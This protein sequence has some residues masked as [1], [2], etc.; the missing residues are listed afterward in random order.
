MAWVK[1]TAHD[2]KLGRDVAIKVV[3]EAFA[4][5]PDRLARFQREAQAIAALNHPNIVTIYSIEE[6]DNHSIM[7]MELVEGHSLAEVIPKGGLPLERLLQIAI[8][9]ADALAAAHQKGITHRDLKPANIMLGD[10]EHQ[11]RVK[12][13]DFGLA[14]LAGAAA[15]PAGLSLLPTAPV[16]GEGRI[17][18]TVAYMSPEQAEGK[19]IDSRSDLF[20]LGIILYEMATGQRPFTGE[21][22]LSIMASIVRDTPT[23]VTT[24]N[25]ALPRDLG[26]IIRRALSK[27]LERRYQTAKDLRNDLEELKGSLES[28]E[29]LAEP[30]GPQAVVYRRHVRVWQWAALGLAVVAIVAIAALVGLLRHRPDVGTGQT[31]ASPTQM[32]PLTSTGNSNLPAISPDGKYVAYVQDDNKQQSVWV[33]HIASHSVVRIVPFSLGVSIFGLSVTPDDSFV[34]V[35]SRAPDDPAPALWRV[36]LLGGAPRKV[37]D[38]IASPPGWSPDGTQMAF[39][40]RETAAPTRDTLMV[41]DADGSHPRALATRTRPRKVPVSFERK[42]AQH[43]SGLVVRRPERCRRGFR[44]DGERLAGRQCQR[45]RWK[46]VCARYRDFTPGRQGGVSRSRATIGRCW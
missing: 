16:T 11:Q 42:S 14:K 5:D 46:R 27:D 29:L 17:L 10:G 36:P 18:G 25:A 19:A 32:I 3:P 39:L 20:S 28:G 26:R 43:G 35:V 4:P 15:E 40:V 9:V 8:A 30:V 44:T 23:S 13:L 41:A 22:S 34:D 12:V 33:L 7:T 38:H 45:G 6:I 1:S 2:T 24:R 37:I 21:T 31:T